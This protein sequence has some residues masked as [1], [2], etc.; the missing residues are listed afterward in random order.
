MASGE[1]VQQD[2][3]ER[4]LLDQFVMDPQMGPG[5]GGGA[6]GISHTVQQQGLPPPHTI[7][8]SNG[9]LRGRG[10]SGHQGG[11]VPHSD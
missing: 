7:H 10:G 2:A 8:P 9:N 11:G 4:D 3:V 1:W 5:G 6:G